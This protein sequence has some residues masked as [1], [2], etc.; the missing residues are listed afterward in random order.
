[1]ALAAASLLLALFDLAKPVWTSAE[2]AF[3]QI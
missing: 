3:G 2:A 1:V